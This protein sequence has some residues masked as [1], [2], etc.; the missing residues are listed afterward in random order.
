LEQ[1]FLKKWW[2]ESDFKAPNLPLSLRLKGSGCHCNVYIPIPRSV[3][4]NSVSAETII[5]DAFSY[6]DVKIFFLSMCDVSVFDIYFTEFGAALTTVL[7]VLFKYCYKYCYSDSRINDFENNVSS[8]TSCYWKLYFCLL[9]ICLYLFVCFIQIISNWDNFIHNKWFKYC[10][11]YCY[12]DS[13]KLW[14]VMKG[15]GLALFWF[16]PPFL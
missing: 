8:S 1:A 3:E 9:N 12:S 7:P 14:A 5:N 2:V 6:S 13:R 10:Y 4:I 11:K 16:N 15:G